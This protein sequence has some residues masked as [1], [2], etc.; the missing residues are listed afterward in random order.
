MTPV[1]GSACT[2]K[3]SLQTTSPRCLRWAAAKRGYR[4]ETSSCP[5]QP[6]AV[7]PARN[8]RCSP[9]GACAGVHETSWQSKD[10][11]LAMRRSLA[12]HVLNST[13][14]PYK[15]LP[16]CHLS[17]AHKRR[18]GRHEPAL[19]RK[20]LHRVESGTPRHRGHQCRRPWMLRAGAAQHCGD[21][22]PRAPCRPCQGAGVAGTRF[23]SHNA[24]LRAPAEPT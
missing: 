15:R 1:L 3:A 7:P 4:A 2:A 18:R 24:A 10:G 16:L 21:P 9:K 11:P 14:E 23:Y 12:S 5:L 19:F 6:F 20:V 13:D 22:C 8:C 17:R